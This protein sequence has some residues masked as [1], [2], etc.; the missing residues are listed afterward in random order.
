MKR[1]LD[2][3]ENPEDIKSLS[4]TELEQLAGEIRVEICD[5][6]SK[7]GG[8]LAPNLGAVELTLTLHAS[9]NC[10]KDK[11]IWDVGHQSYTHKILTGRR[12]KELSLRLSKK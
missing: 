2:S 12:R 9:L 5:V 11:I 1:L 4:I 8:H 7:N 6:V 10:P 3:I